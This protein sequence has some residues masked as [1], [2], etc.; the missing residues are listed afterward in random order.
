MA[1]ISAISASLSEAKR[2]IATTT[3]TPNLRTLAI[4]RA[5]F[6]PPWATAAGLAS[7]TSAP[8]TPLCILSERTEATMTAQAGR[9]PARRH[10]MSKN[11][12]AP[13]SAPKP[14]SVTTMS[15]SFSAARVATTEL[16]PWAMLAN[17]PP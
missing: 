14:A 2:L 7:A 4:W 1:T 16:Q 9:R 5:R 13:R 12:S 8:A 6:S 10:L 15:A 17:G 11:F 3:G